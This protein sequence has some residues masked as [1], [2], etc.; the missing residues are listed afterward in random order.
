ME[1][2]RQS[3]GDQRAHHGSGGTGWHRE[4]T[5]YRAHYGFGMRILAV[6]PKPLPKP[7]FVAELHSLD[8]LPKMVPQV[9]VLVCAAPHTKESIGM[10]NESIFRA[11]KPTAYFINMSRGTSSG[12]AGAGSRP[13]RGL[14]CRAPG[15]T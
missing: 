6:D 1:H 9:D 5:A 15:S 12:H 4:R 3:A 11:M 13:Q 2:D 8:W 7:A 10:F 14:D